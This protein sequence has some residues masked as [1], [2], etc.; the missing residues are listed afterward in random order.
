MTTLERFWELAPK[1]AEKWPE[2]L[3]VDNSG[4]VFRVKCA[5]SPSGSYRITTADCTAMDPFWLTMASLVAESIGGHVWVERTTFG[6]ERCW[7]GVWEIDVP[8]D[9]ADEISEVDD[10]YETD[11]YDTAPEAVLAAL[12]ALMEEVLQ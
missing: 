3:R 4:N 9:E 8:E 1:L 2:A 6:N 12:V 11:C 7:C 10:G 5:H